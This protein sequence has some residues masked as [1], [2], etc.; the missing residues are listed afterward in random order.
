M[1]YPNQ[2]GIFARARSSQLLF[3]G[4]EHAHMRNRVA[5]GGIDALRSLRFI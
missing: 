4:V 5:I 1:R 2:P 3:N